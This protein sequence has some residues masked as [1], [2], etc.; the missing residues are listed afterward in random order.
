VEFFG[1]KARMMG[2]GGSA[3]LAVQTGAALTPV[4]L[5]FEGDDSGV[6]VH[7]EGPVPAGGDS[8][9]KASA[10]MQ[11]VA[12]LLEAGISA[13]RRTGTLC[14]ASSPPT[15]TPTEYGVRL[16]CRLDRHEAAQFARHPATAHPVAAGDRQLGGRLAGSA[17]R[18]RRSGERSGLCP[19]S[20]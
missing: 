19:G 4:I 5:W 3:A 11:E 15:R 20:P 2:A 10:M 16:G 9:Q 6:D 1:E 13:I 14:S 18:K 7:E 17:R 8:K 12:R